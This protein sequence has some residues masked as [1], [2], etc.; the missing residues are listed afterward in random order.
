MDKE[1]ETVIK[2][3]N[4]KNKRP[5]VPLS[6]GFRIRNKP[7]QHSIPTNS[8]SKLILEG[9]ISESKVKVIKEAEIEEDIIFDIQNFY[10][11]EDEQYKKEVISKTGAPVL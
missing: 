4:T 8:K 11:E 3:L 5:A 9:K 10:K 1:I 2:I 7:S 6:K